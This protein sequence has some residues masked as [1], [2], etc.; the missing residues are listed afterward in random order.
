MSIVS[1]TYP[2]ASL[3][4][5]SEFESDVLQ[6]AQTHPD[7]PV[8]LLTDGPC[9][10][11]P[12]VFWFAAL[13]LKNQN[14][15][16]VSVPPYEF[17][18]SA[19][20]ELQGDLGYEILAAAGSCPS[21][22]FGP[23]AIGSRPVL[24]A[25]AATLAKAMGDCDNFEQRNGEARRTD[26]ASTLTAKLF[27]IAGGEV[28]TLA[29]EGAVRLGSKFEASD[30]DA[31]R[32]SPAKVFG[33]WSLHSLPKVLQSLDLCESRFPVAPK[34][35]VSAVAARSIAPA[36]SV[37]VIVYDMAR[38][39]M[40]TLFTLSPQNQ[41]GVVPD[42]YEVIVVENRS[43]NNLNASEVEGLGVNFSYLL[44]DESGVSPAAAINDGLAKASGRTIGLMIDG[45]R[46]VTP[47]V[48]ATALEAVRIEPN[49]LLTLPAYNLGQGPHHLNVDYEHDEETEQALLATVPWAENGYL[50]LDVSSM[51]FAHEDGWLLP[52][53][54]CNAMFAPA[55][56]F[57]EIGGADESFQLKGG[58]ALN[59]HMYRQLGLSRFSKQFFTAPSEGSF[60][61]FHGG[62][63]TQQSEAATEV[64]DLAHAE[65]QSHWNDSFSGLKREPVL[66]GA[67]YQ[68]ACWSIRSSAEQLLQRWRFNNRRP[69]PE[70]MFADDRHFA[71]GQWKVGANRPHPPL[72]KLVSC[73]AAGEG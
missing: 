55:L 11:T 59:L 25:E 46:M 34:P 70:D 63:T 39:A 18:G 1:R 33:S 37:I 35:V 8:L 15:L 61:Q 60:H 72:E 22:R 3:R 43:S 52:M 7:C 69:R 5:R 67:V 57:E 73:E 42:D 40:N 38:Q 64:V 21:N 53:I 12:R 23:L 10:L 54:E 44:R 50:L 36:I 56:A 16:L 65:L 14:D 62:V 49:S 47:G 29:G 68:P 51:G 48:I 4:G 32:P 6:L 71:T 2:T 31:D 58:G 30:S 13:A 26:F 66:I 19:E 17:I 20:D 41:V 28:V 9:I 24:I 45:A 27:H